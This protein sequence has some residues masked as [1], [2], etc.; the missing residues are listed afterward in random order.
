V[1]YNDANIELPTGLIQGQKFDLVLR[2][3]TLRASNIKDF[4]K[5]PIPFRA[6]ATDINNG[7]AV[8]FDKGDIALAMRASMAVPA[9]FA[10]V[11]VDGVT[12]VDGGIADNLPIDVVRK[13]GA[14]TLLSHL[15][16]LKVP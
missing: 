12:L 5:L 1:G 6:V 7:K 13:M 4:D 2:K 16:L 8:V 11:E 3:L 10:A 9:I 15:H 14:D